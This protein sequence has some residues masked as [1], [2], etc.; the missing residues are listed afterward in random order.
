MKPNTGR[1]LA[2]FFAVTLLTALVWTVYAG[3]PQI[4]HRLSPAVA[5]AAPSK[6][7]QAP[8]RTMAQQ[9]TK[10]Q[11]PWIT[12][13][14]T[15]LEALK[16]PF[17]SGPEVTQACLSCHTQA[18]AQLH[19]TIHWTWAAGKSENGHDMGKAHKSLNNFCIST[20][21]NEDNSCLACH[22]GQTPWYSD[23]STAKNSIGL[24]KSHRGKWL[25]KQQK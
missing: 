24:E 17:K 18:A 11:A 21:A 22:P 1:F 14:H 13:D 5:F 2:R 9:A 10:S 6:S 23:F 8:G 16:Q 3:L 7:D 12:V 15:Q 20:N 19:Q 4:G 25:G